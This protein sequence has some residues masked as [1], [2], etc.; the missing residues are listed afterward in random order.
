MKVIVI[1]ICCFRLMAIRLRLDSFSPRAD[2]I[3]KL[4]QDIHSGV[5]VNTGVSNTNTFLESLR[6]F[7][8]YRLLALVNI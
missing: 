7:G 2:R 6:S 4:L 1:L 8:R 3:G 5:P